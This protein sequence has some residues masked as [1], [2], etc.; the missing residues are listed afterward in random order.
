MQMCL[1]FLY[2]PISETTLC[3]LP[4]QQ[5]KGLVSIPAVGWRTAGVTVHWCATLQRS[6]D[7]WSHSLFLGRGLQMRIFCSP[8]CARACAKVQTVQQ[9]RVAVSEN[10]HSFALLL[11]MRLLSPA[12]FKFHSSQEDR[13]H[14]QGRGRLFSRGQSLVSWR[15]DS[16]AATLVCIAVALSFWSVQ[17]L[18]LAGGW[19]FHFQLQGRDCKLL[20]HSGFDILTE[21]LEQ[22]QI[23][24]V[25]WWHT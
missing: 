22:K 5:M 16:A 14:I 13:V 8:W 11:T 19:V 2:F 7:A 15:S 24:G 9:L 3:C 4:S 25:F 6:Q 12:L 20:G 1:F 18:E 23:D 17:H 21:R 10:R